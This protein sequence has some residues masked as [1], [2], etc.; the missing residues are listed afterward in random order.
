[1]DVILDVIYS[2]ACTLILIG[3]HRLAE[4]KLTEISTSL[5]DIFSESLDPSVGGLPSWEQFGERLLGLN[6]LELQKFKSQSIPSPTA[7]IMHQKMGEDP[8]TTLADAVNILD[9]IGR[10][11][12]VEL[13]VKAVRNGGDQNTTQPHHHNLY[14]QSSSLDSG[15]GNTR[16]VTEPTLQRSSSLPP[17]VPTKK[18]SQVCPAP[19]LLL[20]SHL[21]L[22]PPPSFLEWMYPSGG[23]DENVE[24]A[25]LGILILWTT[26]F[27][28]NAGS[29]ESISGRHGC[30]HMVVSTWLYTHI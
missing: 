22:L 17:P 2:W 11:D 18:V 29:A 12:V 9:E 27:A 4:M 21:T 26:W 3:S 23:G 14:H 20:P 16:A 30:I 6:A 24:S 1:M 10:K 25:A 28:F 7:A 13:I 5:R 8:T 15:Y 19:L